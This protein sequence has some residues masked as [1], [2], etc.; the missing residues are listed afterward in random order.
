MK[1]ID[2]EIRQYVDTQSVGLFDDEKK[3]IILAA[4]DVASRYAQL[5]WIAA[6]NY[7]IGAIEGYNTPDSK[8][9][10]QKWLEENG[11]TDGITKHE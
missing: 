4:K 9:H 6:S 1:N 5:I 8:K 11:F 3:L 7:T 2:E 10:C